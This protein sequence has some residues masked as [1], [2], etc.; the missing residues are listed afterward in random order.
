MGRQ[1]ARMAPR[2]GATGRPSAQPT[3]QGTNSGYGATRADS[4]GYNP[5][6]TL[7]YSA[8]QT[9]KAYTTSDLSDLSP[10]AKGYDRA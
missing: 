8:T 2:Q 4:V 10:K 9:A 1:M 7:A 3:Y 6:N 5:R